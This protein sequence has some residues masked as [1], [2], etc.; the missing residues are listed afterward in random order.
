M[1]ILSISKK[2]STVNTQAKIE[3]ALT[4]FLLCSFRNSEWPSL[5]G[6]L[7]AGCSTRILMKMDSTIWWYCCCENVYQLRCRLFRAYRRRI[8]E[9]SLGHDFFLPVLVYLNSNQHW[10]AVPPGTN[11]STPYIDILL[12]LDLER[13]SPSTSFLI[14]SIPNTGMSNIAW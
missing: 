12:H 5:I 10:A 3:F 9:A 4:V 11:C 1:V 2:V 6:V 7:W 8:F 13:V 14:P